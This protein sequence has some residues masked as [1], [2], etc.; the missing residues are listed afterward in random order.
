M[1]NKSTKTSVACDSRSLLLKSIREQVSD[2]PRQAIPYFAANTA[3]NFHCLLSW[4]AYSGKITDSRSV[5]GATTPHDRNRLPF[6]LLVRFRSAIFKEFS[7]LLA[8]VL[9]PV[10]CSWTGELLMYVHG[11]TREE[12]RRVLG[13]DVVADAPYFLVAARLVPRTRL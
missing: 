4:I 9:L 3:K 12:S 7:L 6:S 10:M 13:L 11:P 8:S 5:Q 1:E 2:Q